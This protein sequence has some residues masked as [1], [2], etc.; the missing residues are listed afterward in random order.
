MELGVTGLFPME[1]KAGNDLLRIRQRFPRVQLLGGVDKRIL[2]SGKGEEDIDREL[3]IVS[4][5]LAHGGYIPHI[6]HHVPDDSC[7]KN[8]RLYREK[9][10]ALIDSTFLR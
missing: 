4:R 8:F 1:R 2:V 5:T 6:D 9:L 7:W 10:N 3:A